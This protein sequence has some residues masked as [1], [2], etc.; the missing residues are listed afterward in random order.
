MIWRFQHFGRTWNNLASGNPLGAILTD[1]NGD[2]RDWSLDEF[3]ETGRRDAARFVADL[4]RIAPDARR[5]RLLDFGCGVGRV[6][7]ALAVHFDSVVG[8]DIAPAM[9]KQARTLHRSDARCRFVVSGPLHLRRFRRGTFDVIYSRL[10]LQHVP[11]QLVR[12]YVRGFMRVLAP[13]GVLMFQLPDQMWA[14]PQEAFVNAPVTGGRWKQRLPRPVVRAW[15]HLKYW[16]IADAPPN[17]MAM[18]GLPR[19]EVLSVIREAGGRVVA[20][21]PDQSHGPTPAGY[22]YWVARRE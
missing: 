2:C 17:H 3:F 12:V 15:R 9:I 18:F 11:P 14:E 13:G 16:V 22:E 4:G 7:R 6:T 8:M 19:D 20:V 5:R 21:R 1:T 10:V